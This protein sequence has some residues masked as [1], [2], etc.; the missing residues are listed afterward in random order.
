MFAVLFSDTTADSSAA[1]LYSWVNEIIFML[2]MKT[3]GIDVPPTGPYW[4]SSPVRQQ[5]PCVLNQ[6]RVSLMNRRMALWMGVD[7]ETVCSDH[8]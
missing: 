5:D 6:R 8:D 2:Y 4:S 7:V 1:S 3:R